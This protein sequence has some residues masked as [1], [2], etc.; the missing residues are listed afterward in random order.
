MT[1]SGV[2]T[3]ENARLTQNAAATTQ[4]AA[5]WRR[6]RRVS[7][8]GI[9][10]GMPGSAAVRSVRAVM[11]SHP[12][13]AVRGACLSTGPENEDARHDLSCPTKDNDDTHALQELI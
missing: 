2:G 5:E 13:L 9:P 12:S 10:A 7:P 4:N 1:Y 3:A 11:S 8:A 6:R